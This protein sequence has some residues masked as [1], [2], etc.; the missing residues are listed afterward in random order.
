[1]DNEALVDQIVRSLSF[2]VVA[3]PENIIAADSTP[4]STPLNVKIK[5]RKKSDA[6]LRHGVLSMP[7]VETITESQKDAV[8]E[9]IRL[10]SSDQTIMNLKMLVEADLEKNIAHEKHKLKLNA[11]TPGG[12]ILFYTE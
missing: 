10:V 7:K 6:A 9:R 11:I 8:P 12:Y 5:V 4:E 3:I 2:E 1:M